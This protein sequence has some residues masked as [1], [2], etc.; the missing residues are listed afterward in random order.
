MGHVGTKWHLLGLLWDL[1]GPIL[2]LGV[3]NMGPEGTNMAPEGTYSGHK[4]TKM[5]CVR[6][7]M[8]LH[9]TL[10]GVADDQ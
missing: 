4:R 9:M 7:D 1:K 6:T 5:K 2:V 3:I 10:I 8:D